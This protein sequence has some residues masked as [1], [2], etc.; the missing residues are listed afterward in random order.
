MY[1]LCEKQRKIV[2]DIAVPLIKLSIGENNVFLNLG[3]LKGNK[4]EGE[5][6]FNL[7]FSE[8]ISALSDSV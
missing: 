1:F 3:R 6:S 7:E 5:T 4:K 8:K 2:L